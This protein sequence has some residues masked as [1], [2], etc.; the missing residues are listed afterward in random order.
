MVMTKTLNPVSS[1]I[2]QQPSLRCPKFLFNLVQESFILYI[3]V[4]HCVLLGMK[5][6]FLTWKR[7]TRGFAWHI[8][9]TYSFVYKIKI[10]F[11]GRMGAQY[12]NK[13]F[14]SI[15]FRHLFLVYVKK[16]KVKNTL[17]NNKPH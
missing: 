17:R 8:T 11:M 4:F 6:F 3:N 10:R 15:Q 16:I 9:C 7:I 12:V 14:L 5:V 1:T 2:F 13:I